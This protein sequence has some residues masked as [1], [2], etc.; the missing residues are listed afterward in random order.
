MLPAVRRALLLATVLLALP[1]TASAKLLASSIDHGN[2]PHA[3][4]GK[5]LDPPRG[6]Y[7]LEVRAEPEAPLGVGLDWQCSRGSHNRALEVDYQP[8]VSPIDRRLRLPMRKPDWCY[9][10][11]DAGFVDTEVEGMIS[12]KLFGPK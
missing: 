11:I 5:S 1:V 4:F 3:Y 2:I 8:L 12:L 10:S 9:V 6:P 7:R